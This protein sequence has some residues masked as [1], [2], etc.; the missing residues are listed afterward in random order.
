[1]SFFFPC[2][3]SW[4]PTASTC[5]GLGNVHRLDSGPPGC[6]GPRWAAQ[7]RGGPR[8][9]ARRT[10]TTGSAC[11]TR[12]TNAADPSCGFPGAGD[13]WLQGMRFV[14]PRVG[15]SGATLVSTGALDA[16]RAPGCSH[17]TPLEGRMNCCVP[18]VDSISDRCARDALEEK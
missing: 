15:R 17:R 5:S 10:Q 16:S 12:R 9:C 2:Q 6:H 8:A 3:A 4:S 11:D 1:V 14:T 13:G 7:G 18:F